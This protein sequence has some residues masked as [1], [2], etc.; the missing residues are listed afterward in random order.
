MTYQDLQLVANPNSN[1][2]IYLKDGNGTY[3]EI[4]DTFDAA[5]TTMD[6]LVFI[7]NDGE[8]ITRHYGDV[9]I[10]IN[11]RYFDY[12]E[13]I[14]Y[15][16]DATFTQE[17]TGT[18]NEDNFIKSKY[19]A[20]H[21]EISSGNYDSNKIYYEYYDNEYIIVAHAPVCAA[22]F[23]QIRANNILYISAL[24]LST[25]SFNPNETYYTSD[26]QEATASLKADNYQINTYY[27]KVFNEAS[28]YTLNK[29]YYIDAACQTP[30]NAAIDADNYT[31]SLYYIEGPIITY[32]YLGK[33]NYYTDEACKKDATT[34]VTAK[35]FKA[36][37]YYYRGGVLA[38]NYNS[39]AEYYIDE[40]LTTLAKSNISST[41]YQ[42]NQ[43]YINTIRKVLSTDKYSA[44]VTYHADPEG[45]ELARGPVTA[46]TYKPSTY[47][48]LG[49][50]TESKSEILLS[51]EDP[52][53]QIKNNIGDT[54]MEVNKNK[55]MI[56]G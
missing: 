48:I 38:D 7:N 17:A 53:L 42:P 3:N 21:Y 30:V 41:Q 16:T 29:K 20:V 27:K 18:L 19:Y 24:S 52:Y 45:N 14:I 40:L 11:D 56:A 46:S 28:A 25:A 49:E 43:Y 44:E 8:S 10:E 13:R 6:T 54:V 39:N 2:K 33:I 4:L 51:S 36:G 55:A 1:Y 32:S 35:N 5:H 37:I 47:Y 23:N 50:K 12:D 31:A 34:G 26:G 22:T 9:W 15:Y